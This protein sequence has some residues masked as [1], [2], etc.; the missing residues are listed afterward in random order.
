MRHRLPRTW[1]VLTP[2][3][4]L[5]ACCLSLT[6]SAGGID[7]HDLEPF[8]PPCTLSVTENGQGRLLGWGAVSG[9]SFYRAGRIPAGSALEDLVET[10][11]RSFLDTTYDPDACYEYVVVAYDANGDKICS[12]R[13]TDVGDCVG[14]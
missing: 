14:D 11:G 12:A 9:A 5:L 7:T 8:G 4:C 3:C 2:A 6:A 13:V 1:L 10:S